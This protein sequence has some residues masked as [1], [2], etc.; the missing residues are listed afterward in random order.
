MEWYCVWWPWLTSKCVVQVCQHQLS[1][2]FKRI[3]RVDA[4]GVMPLALQEHCGCQKTW[5]PVCIVVKGIWPVKLC[6]TYFKTTPGKIAI[7]MMSVCVCVCVCVCLFCQ[8]D[9]PSIAGVIEDL[10]YQLD[11]ND[12]SSQGHKEKKYCIDTVNV[13]IPR[14]GMEMT[15]FLRDGM[16]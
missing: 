12:I 3:R 15:G 5:I 7:K 11:A 13:K 8:A 10:D 9:F 1:F 2:L 14:K 6:T 16:S 4:K